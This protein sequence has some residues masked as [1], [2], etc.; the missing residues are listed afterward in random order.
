MTRVNNPL[1]HLLILFSTIIQ[2]KEKD[3]KKGKSLPERDCV[4]FLNE[5]LESYYLYVGGINGL[6][7]DN[8]RAEEMIL[9]GYFLLL[10]YL[11]LIVYFILFFH[12][13]R[14]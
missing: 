4:N 3:I 11:L 13:I 2:I 1:I 10:H 12:K 9:G 6:T 8:I 7:Y 5:A 14:F